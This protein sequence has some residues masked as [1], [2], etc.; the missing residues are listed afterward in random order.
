[1][2]PKHLI[3]LAAV[4]LVMVSSALFYS[5]KKE[6]QGSLDSVENAEV[7]K[8][9]VAP[10]TESNGEPTSAVP[11]ASI[12]PQLQ[13]LADIL[14]S[15]NDNDP[16]MDQI[17]KNLS[18]PV[19]AALREQYAQ[20]KPELRNER[21]TIAFLLGRELK[22]GR[23]NRADVDFLASV[24]MEKPCRSL[25]DCSKAPS[26]QSPE[27]QHLE[28]IHETTVHYPQLMSLRQVRQS[29]EAGNLTS[30]LRSA[31]IAALENARNSPNPRVVQ[32]ANAI[33]LSLK[34]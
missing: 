24:L 8:N 19:K 7:K 25:S 20:T 12:H 26:S 31:V 30:E 2:K 33:L 18:E 9:E 29:I 14:Q 10:E 21:G 15:K 6:N 22:E 5:T 1:M 16:R 17:L 32:E 34:Q 11:A 4:I 27:E 23:G 28:A 3:S 13:V